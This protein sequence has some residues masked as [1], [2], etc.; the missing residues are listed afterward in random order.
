MNVI[1]CS[2][3]ISTTPILDLDVSVST[4][5]GLLRSGRERTGGCVMT[6]FRFLKA[7]NAYSFQANTSFFSS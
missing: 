6:F 3:Y 4:T 2:S 5:K 1:R 7:L